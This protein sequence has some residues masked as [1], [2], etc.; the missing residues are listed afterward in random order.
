[1]NDNLSEEALAHII[2]RL[3]E[4]AKEAAETHKKE[5]TEHSG[6]EQVAYYA[7]LDIIQSELDAY[8]IDLKKYNLDV[9]LLK[10]LF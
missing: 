1:M 5:K 9:D 6:G 10:T 4:R 2:A 3:L 8:D 7:M